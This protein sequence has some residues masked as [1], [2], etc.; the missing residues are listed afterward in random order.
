MVISARF[1]VS[2][3]AEHSSATSDCVLL[4]GDNEAA[5]LWVRR[6]R[7]DKEPRSD[8]LMR[9]I[10]VIELSSGWHFDA[11]HVRGIFNVAA[12][13]NSRWGRSSVLLN[14]RSVRPDVPWQARDLGDV[15]TSLCTSVLAS[16]S[17]EAPFR[18]RLNALM[19]GI[20]AH[21]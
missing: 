9:L 19:R 10:G 3:C 12:E 1:L 18:P 4:R 15:G 20:L 11:K 7:G 6:C 17:C 13:G 5:M 21:G 8:A 14:L 2:S 16:D